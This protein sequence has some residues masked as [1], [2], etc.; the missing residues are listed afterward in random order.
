MLEW[1]RKKQ[2]DGTFKTVAHGMHDNVRFEIVKVGGFITMS[3]WFLEIYPIY[4][5]GLPEIS[6]TFF[7]LNSAK[8]FAE[9]MNEERPVVISS[10]NIGDCY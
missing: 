4:S 8:K 1:K 7:S 10:I 9:N 3:R 2:K 6:L 5:K